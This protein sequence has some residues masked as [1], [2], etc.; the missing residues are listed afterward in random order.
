M[1]PRR[2]GT[3]RHALVVG[4][5]VLFATACSAGTPTGAPPSSARS[6]AATDPVTVRVSAEGAGKPIAADLR[7]PSSRWTVFKGFAVTNDSEGASR[8]V[9]LW[10]VGKVAKDPCHPIGHLYDP[11]PTVADLVTALE[12]QAIRHP[13][14]PRTVTLAEHPATYLTWSVPPDLVV[15]GDSD[16]TGCDVQPDGH[17]NFLSWEGIGGQGQRW[18][19]MAGQVDQLWIFDIDGQRVVMDASHSPNATQAQIAEE[20]QVAQSLRFTHDA[21]N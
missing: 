2:T 3:A 12:A 20:D 21:T 7:V 16:F 10:E 11:G 9:S 14:T 5:T 19:Q 4:V 6:S 8:T 15:T 17:R 1:S 13:S 18:Q